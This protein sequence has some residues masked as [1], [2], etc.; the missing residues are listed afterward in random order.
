MDRR[1][2]GVRRPG[3]GGSVRPLVYKQF[4]DGTFMRVYTYHGKA[5]ESV[6]IRLE[7]PDFDAYL[8]L[9]SE[10]FEVLDQDDDSAGGT[11]SRIVHNL[12]YTGLYYIVV[13]TIFP[14]EEGEYTLWIE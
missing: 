4:G 5:G 7:S 2:R 9:Y 8:L 11:D 12:P 14:D 13:N 1:R 10:D 6:D 3:S